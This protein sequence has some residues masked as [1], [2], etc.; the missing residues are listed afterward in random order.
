MSNNKP[1]QHTFSN[2]ER[3]LGRVL[4][5]M[6]APRMLPLHTAMKPPPTDVYET[7]TEIII[8][9]ELPGMDPQ[10]IS[11]VADQTTVSISGGRLA[12]AFADTTSIHQLEIEHGDFRRIIPLPTA[13][14]VSA[15][16]STCKNGFLKVVLPKHQSISRIEVEVE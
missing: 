14:D 1:K 9:M 4:K 6:S 13:I 8:F 16:R 10:S 12:P 5:D 7:A 15:T 2:L 3:H 11:V